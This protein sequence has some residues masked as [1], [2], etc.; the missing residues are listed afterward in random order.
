MNDW[1]AP[2]E[3]SHLAIPYIGEKEV[4]FA[5]GFASFM[6]YQVMMEMGVMTKVLAD[7]AYHSKFSGVAEYF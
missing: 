3:M 7:R 1:T 4:W 2:H 6:Q 5:E